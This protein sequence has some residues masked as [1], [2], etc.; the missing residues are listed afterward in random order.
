[1]S[2]KPQYVSLHKLSQLGVLSVRREA[3]TLCLWEGEPPADNNSWACHEAQVEEQT[4]MA[5]AEVYLFTW[6]GHLCFLPGLPWLPLGRWHLPKPQVGQSCRRQLHDH[7]PEGVCTSASPA[8]SA[9][10]LNRACK[11]ASSHTS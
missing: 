9:C 5:A 11:P 7:L 1:M 3:C 4:P 2:S 10:A 8:V 6:R